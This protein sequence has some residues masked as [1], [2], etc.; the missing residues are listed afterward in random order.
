VTT[1]Y[2]IEELLVKSDENLIITSEKKKT[3]KKLPPFFM[4]GV[5]R[6][7]TVNG[8]QIKKGYPLQDTLLDFNAAER[9]FFKILK[10]NITKNLKIHIANSRFT[11][12]EQNKKSK[13][14]KSLIAIGLIKKIKREWYMLNP[15][16]F[17]YV[18]EYEDNQAYWDSLP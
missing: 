15:K 6:M 11:K 18:N 1:F 10:E 12:V 2:N 13:A 17:I 14:V 8:K 4:G 16:A 7:I 3:R 9:W 5:E